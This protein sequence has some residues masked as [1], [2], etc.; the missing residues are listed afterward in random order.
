MYLPCG[1]SETQWSKLLAVIQ[2]NQRVA[3]RNHH[4]IETT[5]ELR[6]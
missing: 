2:Q 3:Y 1:P 5:S 6:E 4:C